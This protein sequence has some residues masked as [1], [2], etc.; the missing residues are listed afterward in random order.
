MKEDK[1]YT[2]PL[3]VKEV[4]DYLL[5]KD[6]VCLYYD[7]MCLTHGDD[8]EK[9]WKLGIGPLFLWDL[10][11]GLVGAECLGG[12]YKVVD[13]WIRRNGLEENEVKIKEALESLGGFEDA[14]VLDNVFVL[15][16]IR[17]IE[18]ECNFSVDTEEG[19][20]NKVKD[21]MV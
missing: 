6:A 5:N 12:T 2:H 19:N 8:F 11:I 9:F 13:K 15:P 4:N 17:F 14:E 20:L 16:L 7:F 21:L 1:V 10:Y 3:Q 18:E